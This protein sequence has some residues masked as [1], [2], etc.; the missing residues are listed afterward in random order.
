M[1]HRYKLVNFHKYCPMCK[2]KD[3]STDDE[4]CT[5]CLDY[6]AMEHST[7]PINF[8]EKVLDQDELIKELIKREGCSKS[9]AK[10][11]LN[12]CDNDLE[13]ASRYV[14]NYLL[15]KVIPNTIENE[16]D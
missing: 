5:S 2:H 10:K 7:K 9:V 6:P 4:P 12:I 14:R 15:K 16:N 8:E 11:A 13:E 3:N 1:E